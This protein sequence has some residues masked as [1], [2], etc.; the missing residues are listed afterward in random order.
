MFLLIIIINDSKG[1]C[2]TIIT[3]ADFIDFAFGDA[4]IILLPKTIL[5]KGADTVRKSYIG[6]WAASVWFFISSFS[7]LLEMRRY[8]RSS[9]TTSTVSTLFI[10]ACIFA[11]IG[12]RRWKEY[13]EYQEDRRIRNEYYKS[14]TA[15]ANGTYTEEPKAEKPAD[16]TTTAVYANG[17]STDRQEEPA[18]AIEKK[19]KKQVSAKAVL[20]II[21]GVIVSMAIAMVV[22]ARTAPPLK[23]SFAPN[24]P[25]KEQEEETETPQ[26]TPTFENGDIRNYYT[27]QKLGY[28]MGDLQEEFKTADISYRYDHA[29]GILYFDL[30]DN[31]YDEYFIE[32]VKEG[33]RQC[34]FMWEYLV[35]R[36]IAQQKRIQHIVVTESERIAH[37]DDDT[38]IVFNLHDPRNPKT[39]FLT[40]AN[41]TAGYD[42]VKVSEE[43]PQ[44]EE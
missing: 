30:T 42:I 34:Q 14:Q 24:F 10:L 9:I 28:I 22:I 41:G 12:Y 4:I 6:W 17:Y 23:G 19:S 38:C 3:Q 11:F 37:E 18:T 39:V 2:N 43:T 13:Q 25:P 16:D 32:Q 44:T 1:S 35:K 21:I 26:E 15:K 8:Y 27:K 5:M 40:V 36:V 7:A 31:T 33:D 29:N 20:A